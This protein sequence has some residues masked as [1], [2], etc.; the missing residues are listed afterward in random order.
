MKNIFFL[1]L[2]C[3]CTLLT[4]AQS[5]EWE[6]VKNVPDAGISP[7]VKAISNGN[8]LYLYQFNEALPAISPFVSVSHDGIHF[9][10]V[11]VL[12]ASLGMVEPLFAWKNEIYLRSANIPNRYF[13][14][15]DGITFEEFLP[16][17]KYD[18]FLIPRAFGIVRDTL[19]AYCQHFQKGNNEWRDSLFFMTDGKQWQSI[20]GKLYTDIHSN[21][22]CEG[23]LIVSSASSY[24]EFKSL[25]KAPRVIPKTTVSFHA[26]RWNAGKYIISYDANHNFNGNPALLL[27]DM[28]A[29]TTMPMPL[30]QPYME[31][32]LFS[33]MVMPD[34]SIVV[35]N[36]KNVLVGNNPNYPYIFLYQTKD[37]GNK[38]KVIDSFPDN[39]WSNKGYRSAYKHGN[40]WYMANSKLPFLSSTNEGV[41]WTKEM[42]SGTRWNTSFTMA[43]GKMQMNGKYFSKDEGKTWSTLAEAFNGFE[44]GEIYWRDNLMGWMVHPQNTQDSYRIAP[45]LNTPQLICVSSPQSFK[46]ALVV[47]DQIVYL[48]RGGYADF[49]SSLFFKLNS[50][51]EWSQISKLRDIIDAQP[52]MYMMTDGQHLYFYDVD[53]RIINGIHVS[54]DAGQ[55]WQLLSR[56]QLL[57]SDKTPLYSFYDDRN[58]NLYMSIR[59][60]DGTTA[61]NSTID[62]IR[63]FKITSTGYVPVAANGFSKQPLRQNT[64]HQAFNNLIGFSSGTMYSWSQHLTSRELRFFKSIDQGENWE[65]INT[66]QIKSAVLNIGEDRKGR[67]YI[68]T[69]NGLY[70]EVLDEEVVTSNTDV[71][72]ENKSALT[73]YPNPASAY[74]VV[75]GENMK[76]VQVL[77]LMGNI[78]IDDIVNDNHIQLDTK[79]LAPGMY[80]IKT[81]TGS[82][83][84]VVH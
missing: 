44:A 69:S 66:D 28:K 31:I 58:K 56:P 68:A 1:M 73:V 29:N 51:K 14:S 43:D 42:L 19:V 12:D 6:L 40:A 16:K 59:E 33:L 65:R 26:Q 9:T 24:L 82:V 54:S 57:V 78:L 13:K 8:A 61:N 67:I 36:R 27:T 23:E 18:G 17:D 39:D 84:L 72:T 20:Y 74:T 15:K 30:P 7:N 34:A 25:Q 62:T 37:F 53:N 38:W 46:E 2:L 79:A 75:V 77:D 47:K 10:P 21:I 76:R 49:R 60:S 71:V 52:A 50:N 11:G 5:K 32:N 83:K 45:G 70:R 64:A 35:Q 41:S 63:M 55:T 81:Q 4:Y 48:E 80:I 3:F 22:I